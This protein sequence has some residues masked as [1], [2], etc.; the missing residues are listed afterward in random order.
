MR[1]LRDNNHMNG[2]FWI[3]NSDLPLVMTENLVL[4]KTHSGLA[5]NKI[6]QIDVDDF[7]NQLSYI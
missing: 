5:T 6:K 4:K 2:H 3:T 1:K 7:S